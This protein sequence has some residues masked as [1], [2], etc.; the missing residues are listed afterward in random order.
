MKKLFNAIGIIS[1]VIISFVYTEKTMTVVREYDDIMIEIRKQNNISKIDGIIEDDTII[2]GI[3][4]RKINI[5]ESYRRMKKIGFYNQELLVYEKQDNKTS[6]KNNYDK[7]IIS[8]NKSKNMISL[9][10]ILDWNTNIENIKK[11]I[12]RNEIEVSFVVDENW[13]SNNNELLNVLVKENHSI[14]IKEKNNFNWVNMII[15]DVLKQNTFCYVNNKDN[16]ILNMCKN[17]KINTIL[18]IEIKNNYL[19][20]TKKYLDSGVLLSYKVSENLEKNLDMIIK[21]IKNKGYTI[22]NIV[23]H[24]EE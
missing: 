23:E 15:Q 4:E 12:N 18:P 1:L 17:K 11:I 13:I 6:L 10:F 3:L 16:E 21:Y 8:G 5:N 9:I 24:L 14:I 7:Y 2:P 19:I 22:S 20:E